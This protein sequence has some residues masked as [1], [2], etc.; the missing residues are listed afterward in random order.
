MY[1]IEME[2]VKNTE[3]RR[4]Q[5]LEMYSMFSARETVPSTTLSIADSQGWLLWLHFATQEVKTCWWTKA[6]YFL[7][8]TWDYFFTDWN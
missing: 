7:R 3:V 8:G 1:I 5:H 4:E 6:D 2:K